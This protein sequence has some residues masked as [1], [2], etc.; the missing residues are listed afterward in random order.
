[1]KFQSSSDTVV[2]VGELLHPSWLGCSST[3]S[4]RTLTAGVAHW[5]DFGFL[6]LYSSLGPHRMVQRRDNTSA[7]VR[8]AR[9]KDALKGRPGG[10]VVLPRG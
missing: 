2:W 10:S 9:E 4:L 3:A 7:S 5:Q 6:C 8:L 1:M